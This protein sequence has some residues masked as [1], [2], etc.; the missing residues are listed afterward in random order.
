[1]AELATIARPYAN[2]VFDLAKRDA[3]LDVWSATL[4]LL[5]SIIQDE[6]VHLLLDSPDMAA[7]VK[8][9][10]LADICGEDIPAAGRLFL[11]S[12]ADNDRL[13][14]IGEVREQ[15]ETLR[16]EEQRSLEV[17][18]ISAFPL[19][20]EQSNEIKI[21]LDRRFD[22]DVTIEASVDESL[23][24]GALIRAGDV[25]IDGSVRGKLNKLAETLVQV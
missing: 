20:D 16:A 2:A 9:Q 23:L 19:T 5:D 6:H 17:Q 4:A 10:K 8:A 14:L 18:V 21:A 25:V 12:L 13:S 15:F 11:Q 3:S 7:A 22:K 24:G 1:M